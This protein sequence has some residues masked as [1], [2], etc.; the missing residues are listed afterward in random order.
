M[1][2][3]YCLSSAPGLGAQTYIRCYQYRQSLDHIQ[4]HFI[5][6]ALRKREHLGDWKLNDLYSKVD[7]AVKARAWVGTPGK[8][9]DWIIQI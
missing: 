5:L 1:F 3:R 7:K 4:K 6:L 2:P 8:G 9:R